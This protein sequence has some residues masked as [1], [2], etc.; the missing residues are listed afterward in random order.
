MVQKQINKFRW[1][2]KAEK[3][4]RRLHQVFL[5]GDNIVTVTPVLYDVQ[6]NWFQLLQQWREAGFPEAALVN[7]ASLAAAAVA[8]PPPPPLPAH[9]PPSAAP[10]VPTWAANRR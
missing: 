2:R 6:K 3:R 10:M 7:P 4:T 1:K 5:R 9:F 8:L